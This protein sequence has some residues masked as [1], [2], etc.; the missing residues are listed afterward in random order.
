[1]VFAGSSDHRSVLFRNRTD[2]WV[3]IE[4]EMRLAPNATVGSKAEVAPGAE[5]N[6]RF[7]GGFQAR[8]DYLICDFLGHYRVTKKNGKNLLLT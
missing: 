6:W 8:L 2:V 1:M 5:Y 3:R 7:L 4:A